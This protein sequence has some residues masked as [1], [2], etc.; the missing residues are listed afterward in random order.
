MTKRED[1][2]FA[3]RIAEPLREPEPVEPAF[4][5]RVLSAVR[6]AA[7]RGDAPWGRAPSSRRPMAWLV[8]PRRV[9]VSPLA[10]LAIAAGFAAVVAATTL[11]LTTRS[12]ARTAVTEESGRQVVHFAIVAPTAS[13]VTLVG[14]FNAWNTKTTPM[15]KGAVEG[16]WMV[17]I[18]LAAG[19]YEYAFVLDGT[20]WMADPA[21]AIALEDE[22]GTPS[23]LLT[24]R[25][26]RT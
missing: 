5:A 1:L 16:L 15:T 11:T 21:A 12:V 24:I 17:T 20:T 7:D 10:G 8:A 22:F 3:R 25:S 6:A 14:D 19:S 23:S 26:N 4:E 18:P 13:A 9:T 2:E